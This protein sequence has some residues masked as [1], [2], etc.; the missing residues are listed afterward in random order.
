MVLSKP[1]VEI[2]NSDCGF[3]YEIAFPIPSIDEVPRVRSA[4]VREGVSLPPVFRGGIVLHCRFELFDINVG[5]IDPVAG[6]ED[7]VDVVDKALEVVAREVMFW[8]RRAACG[9]VERGCL[10]GRRARQARSS[11]IHTVRCNGRSGHVCGVLPLEE[12][13]QEK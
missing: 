11:D 13:R 12:A 2:R 8:R 9:V 7:S 5:T 10:A 3:T 6:A 1:V 4:G